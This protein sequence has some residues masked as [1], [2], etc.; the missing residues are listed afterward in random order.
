MDFLTRSSPPSPTPF[1]FPPT[2]ASPPL[3]AIWFT[4][5]P[6]LVSPTSRRAAL[7][8]LQKLE[9]LEIQE[10][11]ESS[12]LL[13]P[14]R[15]SVDTATNPRTMPIG[16]LVSHH[17]PPRWGV[18]KVSN[19]PYSITK[20]EI[21]QF[22]GR[23]AN[24]ITAD[25]GCPIHIIMER[26]TAKTMDCYAEFQSVR[27]AHDTVSYINRVHENGR[28]PR[29]GN[30]HVDVELSD[31][32]ALLRDLFPR[33]KCVIWKGGAPSLQVNND[34]YCSGFA[35]LFT[36]EEIELAIRH[37][38]VPQRSPF[39][40]KC[41]QRTYESTISTLHKFPWYATEMYTV[42]H[43]N[44]LFEL[45]NRH[46]KCLVERMQKTN[47]VGLDQKL[48]QDLLHAGL[49]CPAFNDRQKYTLCMH[50]E[51]SSEIN[52]MPESRRWFP[53]DTLA[54]MPNYH[55]DIH[56]YFAGLISY[57]TLPELDDM[58]ENMGLVNKFPKYILNLRSPYGCVWF[59]WP[60]LSNMTWKTAVNREM[61]ILSSLVF[62]GWFHHDENALKSRRVSVESSFSLAP[63]D[64]RNL[65]ISI[66]HGSEMIQA[67]PE[68]STT[69]FR[70]ASESGGIGGVAS[71]H[72]A[73]GPWNQ[74]ILLNAPV[75]A[76]PAYRGHRNTQSSPMC[77]PSP[78]RNPWAQQGFS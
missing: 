23:K 56:D 4:R 51:I 9:D 14:Y 26:S 20:Q 2:I 50:S 31:Q 71:F 19:I 16:S 5:Q 58:L 60:E 28:S 40:D 39:C 75:R 35:G 61:I 7:P 49:K 47:T 77:L 24:L 69:P 29:L 55:E 41:P 54:R 53:F 10:N 59:E 66:P 17:E 37:A 48:L 78:T 36:S 63:G 1:F 13:A 43:R 27:D 34:S 46:I 72:N 52:K 44:R 3:R 25:Q 22:L 6:D 68:T 74:A 32:N 62:N 70:R 8:L 11:S 42:Y 65:S 76:R 18:V 33:A 21:F 57:G 15:Q 12:K 45:T 73:R 64:R 67:D 38:E 30:R